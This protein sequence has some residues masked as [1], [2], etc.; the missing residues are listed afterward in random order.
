MKKENKIAIDFHGN[1]DFYSLIRGI[2]I[3]LKFR[4]FTETNKEKIIIIN[5]YIERNFVGIEYEFDIDL[6][7]AFE[8][9]KNDVDLI[10]NILEDYEYK[11]K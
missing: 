4:D 5:K 8:D 10:K 6:D 1:R 9:I 2:A 7:L 11:N 3:E